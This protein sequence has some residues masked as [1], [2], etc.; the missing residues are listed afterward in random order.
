MILSSFLFCVSF[1]LTLDFFSS[2]SYSRITKSPNK[3]KTKSFLSILYKYAIILSV[4]YATTLIWQY[5][6]HRFFLEWMGND[7]RSYIEYASWIPRII[8]ALF[9]IALAILVYLDLKAVKQKSPITTIITL[10]FGLIGVA[11]M[12]IQLIYWHIF[13]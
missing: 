12:L 1:H 6:G 5:V 3:M 13:F 11:I 9:Q 4:L 2:Y 7:K 10:L 8:R